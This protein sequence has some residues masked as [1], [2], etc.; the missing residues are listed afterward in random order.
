MNRHCFILCDC[1]PWTGL[2]ASHR[3]NHANS[4]H[5]Q[6]LH[7]LDQ[8]PSSS[9]LVLRLGTATGGLKNIFSQGWNTMRTVFTDA[10]DIIDTGQTLAYLKELFYSRNANSVKIVTLLDKPSGRKAETHT[11]KRFLASLC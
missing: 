10:K 9:I 11:D 6:L 1:P 3:L 8:L 7:A 5:L 2:P 4:D